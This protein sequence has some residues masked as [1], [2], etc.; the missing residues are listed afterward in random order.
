LGGVFNVVKECRQALKRPTMEILVNSWRFSQ[1]VMN[2]HKLT[3]DLVERSIR[4]EFPCRSFG[5][6][7]SHID[8]PFDQS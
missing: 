4:R 1:R 2:R 5:L 7:G 6:C 8:V 3:I